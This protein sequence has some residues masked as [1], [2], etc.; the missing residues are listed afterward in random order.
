VAHERAEPQRPVLRGDPSQIE[1]AKVDDQTGPGQPVG[2]E[3][4]EALS[5]SEN[6]RVL[7]V[8]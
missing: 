8:G 4:H 1:A 2:Q 3:R 6:L 5:T 7:A